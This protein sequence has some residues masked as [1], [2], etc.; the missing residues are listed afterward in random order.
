MLKNRPALLPLLAVT[1]SALVLTGCQPGVFAP[2]DTDAPATTPTAT[3]TSP[4][5]DEPIDEPMDEPTQAPVE[6]D[7]A[8]TPLPTTPPVVGALPCSRVLTADQLYAFNPNFAPVERAA[9]MPP[10]LERVADAGGTVCA[11]R[12][13]TG[14]DELVVGALEDAAGFQAPEFEQVGDLGV[15]LAP[16]GGT[17][18]VVASQYFGSAAEAQEVLDAVAGNF[19]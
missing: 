6:T 8:A 9:A 11:F 17:V 3:E 18:V 4:A 10:A 19:R 5:T 2:T 15:A 1:M 13:V 7:P 14:S 16:V 12:H